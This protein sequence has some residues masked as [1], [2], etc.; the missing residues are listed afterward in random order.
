MKNAY[1]PLASGGGYTFKSLD[2]RVVIIER[3]LF[4]IVSES[5][6]VETHG[7]SALALAKASAES[8]EARLR[9]RERT[10][11]FIYRNKQSKLLRRGA[12][13][14]LYWGIL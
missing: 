14:G 3:S 5:E 2:W 12:L 1:K 4:G 13:L 10:S 6:S 9:E 8:K 7:A 11:V